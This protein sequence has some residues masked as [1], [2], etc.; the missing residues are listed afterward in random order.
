MSQLFDVIFT[1]LRSSKKSVNRLLTLGILFFLV[2]HFYVVEPYF[3]FKAQK[4][5]L[6]ELSKIVKTLPEILNNIQNQ[7]DK[8]TVHLKDV[9]A[10][11]LNALWSR[12]PSDT[13]QIGKIT[14]PIKNKNFQEAVGL[15]VEKWFPNLIEKF[16][17]PISQLEDFGTVTGDAGNFRKAI[18]KAKE[19]AENFQ[20]GLKKLEEE[21]PDIWKDYT[22]EKRWEE[23]TRK[24]QNLVED[25]FG[26]VKKEIPG[27][28]VMIHKIT[29]ENLAKVE[30]DIGEL[31]DRINDLISQFGPVPVSL[32]D[33]I[34]LF[35]LFLTALLV[36][37]TTTLHKSCRLYIAFWREFVKD[38]KKIDRD[39]FQQFADCWYLPTYTS[40]VQPML[41]IALLAVIA[42]LVIRASLLIILADDAEL[43]TFLFSAEESS[44]QNVFTGA[45]VFGTFVV[46]GCF[47]L[48]FKTLRR[49]T[50]EAIK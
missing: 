23:A 2:G 3:H 31:R 7:V 44:R 15:Y 10:Q 38:N 6:L 20:T 9:K 40:F 49:I 5:D 48:I 33:F 11:I 27:L 50:Q 28:Q 21:D 35:P 37:I 32:K 39:A 45:Y 16:K 36:M 22:D 29:E 19:A 1:D 14:L 42:G 18:D 12:Q 24:L 47:G 30:K 46:V 4:L 17:M 13:L 41:L 34:V 26:A 25:S 43:F 8:Y